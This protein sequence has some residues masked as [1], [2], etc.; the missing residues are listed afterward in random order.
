MNVIKKSGS[1]F[2][3]ADFPWLSEYP[4]SPETRVTVS[5]DKSGFDLHFVSS[6][7]SVRAIETE[8]NSMVYR[9]SCMEA[10][11]QFDPEN[12]PRY[13][14][15]EINPNGAVYSAVSYDRA[16]SVCIDPADIAMLKVSTCVREDGWEIHCH[17]PVEYIQKQIPTYRHEAGAHLRANFY[18]CGDMTDHPHF[19]CFQHI[20]W[21]QP[22]FHRPEFFADFI[23]E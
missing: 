10:F 21:S 1:T 3:I 23:L 8:P 7:T 11:W 4:A 19:G 13:I 22:D 17:I 12:D 14:N 5:Y 18:K 2:C 15:F 20:E 6:E 9:D 16:Q